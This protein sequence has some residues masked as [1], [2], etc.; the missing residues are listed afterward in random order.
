M[1]EKRRRKT[2][3]EMISRKKKDKEK[4]TKTKKMRSRKLKNR[5]FLKQ[6]LVG[7]EAA[8]SLTQVPR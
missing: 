1:S 4:G 2:D 3:N 5:K 8:L 7:C 6:W